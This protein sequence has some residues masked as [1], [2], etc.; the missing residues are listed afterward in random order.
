[1]Y[2]SPDRRPTLGLHAGQAAHNT[3]DLFAFEE[4][5]D[6]FTVGRVVYLV[7]FGLCGV[8]WGC[9]GGVGCVDQQGRRRGEG[10]GRRGE[11]E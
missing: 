1:M 11:E 8:V 6:G 9:V 3:G 10:G 2:I 4:E 5:L 7:V